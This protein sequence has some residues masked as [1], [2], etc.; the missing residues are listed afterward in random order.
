MADDLFLKKPIEIKGK[1]IKNRIAYAPMVSVT[2]EN[3]FVVEKTLAWYEARI[4]GGVG[5]CMVEGTNTSPDQFLEFMP[6]MTLHDDKYVESHKSLV[7]LIHA[8]DCHASI[9]LAH[10]GLMAVTARMMFPDF[11]PQHTL[12]RILRQKSSSQSC[13][14]LTRK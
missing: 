5:F 8:Y 3:G 13:S 2:A 4:K 12:D 10:A 1:L 14:T 6:Q 7:N 11:M 9:Q